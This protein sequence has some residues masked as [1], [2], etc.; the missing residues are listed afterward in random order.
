MSI[1]RTRRQEKLKI[2]LCNPSGGNLRQSCQ[3]SLTE[4]LC[5][6]SQR[7]KH[8]N[9][10]HKR[11]PSQTSDRILN[12]DPTRGVANV[13][14]GWNVSAW[15]SWLQAGVQGSGWDSF[16]IRNLTSGDMGI[17][18]VVI[19]LGVTRL[20]KIRLVFLLD[21]F[22][23]WGEKGLCDLVYVESLWMTGLM[24]VI[25]M[26][27]SRVVSVVLVLSGVSVQT[28]NFLHS[29]LSILQQEIFKKIVLIVH[30]WGEK[31]FHLHFE[32]KET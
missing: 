21:L 23:G 32:T 28:L 11:A 10:F 13:G 30:T 14:C 24:V 12:A 5:K 31:N 7:P 29:S 18:L 16:K 25:L 3:I 8:F 22:E 9:C 2:S 19:L 17:L 1:R 27:Y 26:F 20:K 15:N 4:L 6:N